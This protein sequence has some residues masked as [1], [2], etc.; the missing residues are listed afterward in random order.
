MVLYKCT[1]TCVETCLVLVLPCE[2]VYGSDAR[3][4]CPPLDAQL[5]DKGPRGDEQILA[6]LGDRREV[7]GG[8]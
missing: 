8:G 7:G 3:R 5:G 6:A 1:Y 2:E 4:G